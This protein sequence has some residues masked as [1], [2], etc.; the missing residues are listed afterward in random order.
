MEMRLIGQANNVFI[1][2]AREACDGGVAR[3]A[4]GADIESAVAAAMWA[5]SY[6]E[7]RNYDNER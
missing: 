3:A 1:A 2:V 4:P 7:L 6:R 5:P